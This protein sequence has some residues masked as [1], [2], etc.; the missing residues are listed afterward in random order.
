MSLSSLSIRR[1]VLAIVMSIAIVVLGILG[2][3]YLGVREYPSV[4]PPI[5]TVSTTYTGA[6]ADVIES[7]ITEPLEESINGIA[8]IR[9]LTSVSRDGRSTITVE[10][11][12]DVDLETAANDVRD[13][14]SRAV[15][16]LPPDVE[17]PIVSKADADASPIVFLNIQSDTRNLLQLT[18]LANNVF[19]ERFQTIPGVSAVDIWG[20]KK[21]S[22]RLWMD[23]AKLAAYH[24]TPLDVKNAV[25]RE[26]VE[27]PSG[28][29]EGNKT[30]LSI[31]TIGRLHDTGEF[32]DLIIKEENGNIVRLKDVGYATLGA[33]NERTILK[34]DG[35]PM[36]GVVLIAQP[37]ANNIAIANEFYKRLDQIKRDLPSDVKTGIGFDVTEYIRDSITEVE[38]TIFV[39]FGLV[40]L[41][42]FLFLRDWRT[43]IIPVIAIPISLIGAFFIM[44]AANFS[45][46][47]LTLL[48]IVLAIG[49]V[50]DDAIVVLENIYTKIEAGQPPDEAARR[51]SAE[52]FFAI[53]STTIA[54]ASVFLPIIFLQGLTGRLFRE[55]GI[56]IAGSVIISAFV[57]L[58]LTP[59]LSS[60]ILKRR[61]KHN[62]FYNKTEPI[63]VRINTAYRNSLEAFLSR[64][65]T[66]F[67]IMGA[68]LGLIYLFF[69]LI[70][71]ELAPLEDRSG[72]RL[73][74]TAPEGASFEYMDHFMDKLIQTLKD[75]IPEKDAIISVTSPGFGASSS[76]NSGFAFVILTKPDQRERSQ[77]QIANDITPV[78]SK[79]TEART[80]VT[81]QQSIG[82]R[83]GGLPVEYVIQ[84]PNFEKL[85][86]Y[87][88]KFMDAAQKDPTFTI[89]DANLKF[90]K[91]EIKLVID[92]QRARNLGVS[93]IDIAQTIQS[94]FSGQ[95]FGYFI[96][97][98][99]QY[100]VIG[101]LLRDKRNAPIDLKSL[102]VKNSKG[103]LIQLD[104]VVQLTEQSAPPQ[105]YRFNRYVSATVSAGLA[106]GKTIDDGIKAMDR[107]ASNVL[108]ETFSTALS[109]ASKDYAESSSSLLFAFI[110]AIGFIYLVLAAQFESFRDPFIILFTVPLA[111]FGAL[112]SLWYFNQTLNIFSE[113]G[114]IMLIG[115]VTKNGILIVEFANQRK[116]AGLSK[117][118]AIK[119]AAAARLRPILMTSLSTVLGILPIALAL[120]AGSESRV[121]MGIAV[122]GGLIFST[123]LT[124][125]IV[126]AVY[127]YLSRSTATV[128]NV[129]E[130]PDIKEETAFASK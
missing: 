77:Q 112:I 123:F 49:I 25:N 8:G 130:A 108:D 76:V 105:L 74:A 34:R 82:Q 80:F 59:M 55:F 104:N 125:L 118:E 114:I 109:G 6:N 54:L 128:S 65:W 64:R 129:T 102:Y 107:I 116:A 14:V 13:K 32:N 89:V 7:Q 50:V 12:I 41:I 19:K 127:S 16:N 5:I 85:R 106:P 103:D 24:L 4:D 35:T 45:I 84:A 15:S 17:N 63:F 113:I 22:M 88:P 44:Y 28:I 52:I 97:D 72:L 40:V 111:I 3:T 121:S 122:I 29:I 39:A 110:L 18:E 46:N 68:S 93:T 66:A 126:P 36:V 91:P 75:S 20:E 94:A 2:Y 78:I 37:G 90:N 95:R 99:K 9:S 87:L 27:L 51:G 31:R 10:F 57:A 47:V 71:A 58:T 70:P 61:E 83:R 1:P 38:Q 56:V 100:Q 96:K 119:D 43:T 69:R 67:L 33:E 48:G 42:I 117:L 60:K 86:E 62:W 30:E 101:Q 98:G 23:P 115:I 11:D 92:R 53:I 120:G 73:F 26:N 124:L 79:M 21:Y 81:Q